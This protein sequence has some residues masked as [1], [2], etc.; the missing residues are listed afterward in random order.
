MKTL[1][2]AIFS[3]ALLA[4]PLLLGGGAASGMSLQGTTTDPNGILGVVTASGTF[5]VSFSFAAYDPTFASQAP[6]FFGDSAAAL[7]AS[8]SL[9]SAMRA[10]NVS[11]LN[12]ATC[13]ITQIPCGLAIFTPSGDVPGVGVAG[14]TIYTGPCKPPY[15]C[16][17]VTLAAQSVPNPSGPD[18]LIEFEGD[19]VPS[20]VRAFAVWAPTVVPIPGALVMFAP[21]LAG[22][23]FLRRLRPAPV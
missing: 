23:G 17:F 21:A 12:G 5:D 6:H 7:D 19:P 2:V 22:L 20:S 3:A 8:E 4:G 11:G 13:L 18:F 1:R 10:L 15:M 9:G 14:F 16:N